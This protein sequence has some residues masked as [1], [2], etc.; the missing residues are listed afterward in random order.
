MAREAH[1]GLVF[2]ALPGLRLGPSLDYRRLITYEAVNP[3][4]LPLKKL[5]GSARGF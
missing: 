4:G 3:S 2:G 1:F 5:R